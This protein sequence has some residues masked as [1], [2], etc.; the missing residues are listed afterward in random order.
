MVEVARRLQARL[1]R[2]VARVDEAQ[3]D[4]A[5]VDEVQADE[6]QADETRT[7]R[8]Y[9]LRHSVHRP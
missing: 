3:V 9:P 4:E 5:Q 2:S 8:A 7:R 1:V 6:T